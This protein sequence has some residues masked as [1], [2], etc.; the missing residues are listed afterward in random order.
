[1]GREIPPKIGVHNT[2]IT[3]MM[4]HFEESSNDGNFD[5]SNRKT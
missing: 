3:N 2:T 5:I 4:S 1:M